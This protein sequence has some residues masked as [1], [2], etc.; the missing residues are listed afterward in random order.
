MLLGQGKYQEAQ[1]RAE[2]TL[3]Y[4]KEDWYSLLDI[5][6]DNLSLGRAYLQRAQKGQSG[7]YAQSETHLDQAVTGLRRSG[8]QDYVPRGLLARAAL[9]RV[10]GDTDRARAD[11]E[12]AASIAEWGGM[13]LHQADCHL[14]YTRLHL[15]EG[16]VD[17][18]RAS[19][20]TAKAMVEEMGY[21]R[22]D[23]E[24]EALEN[25]LEGV[26]NH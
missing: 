5:A 23:G 18:A 4:E 17:Q 20:A 21:G 25:A 8:R 22:R 12:E 2:Q 19:L 3:G 14:E 16:K 6:L 1:R 24:V 15:A 9:R 10:T 26:L 13:R 7:D 11:L